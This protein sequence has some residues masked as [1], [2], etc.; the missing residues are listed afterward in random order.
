MKRLSFMR[1]YEK[2]INIV[3][4]SIIFSVFLNV[5]I[6]TVILRVENIIPMILLSSLLVAFVVNGFSLL[7]HNR[8]KC[9]VMYYLLFVL[10]LLWLFSSN[11]TADL[12][13]MSAIIFG[14]PAMMISNTKISYYWVTTFTLILGLILFRFI[15]VF[16]WIM[17]SD[18]GE[19]MYNSYLILSFI[20]FSVVGIYIYNKHKVVVV[21]S[22]LNLVIYVPIL[23]AIGVRGVYMSIA[24]FFFLIVLNTSFFAR[25][26]KSMLL[27]V[28][29]LVI[30]LFSID[31]FELIEN[32]R[33]WLADYDIEVYALEKYFMMFSN[34]DVSNGRFQ[35]Y[36]NAIFGF[37]S[38]PVWGNGLGVFEQMNEG[39][40]V[41][42]IFLEVLY[43]GGILLSIV[44]V[45]SFARF[46]KLVY[47]SMDI[48]REYY[49]FVILLFSLGCSILLFSNTLW[50][51]VAFW[52]FF[53]VTFDKFK[54]IEK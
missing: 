14:M 2:N 52:L 17:E 11:E 18:A 8:V 44:F 4:N 31:W 15:D 29:L 22:I 24:L 50:R 5:K 35:L 39:L 47:R 26:K 7:T 38:S 19:K 42:N 3:I 49:T 43:E 51:V 16:S 41:H 9:K 6:F 48:N 37:F 40:Y 34:D 46:S 53:G 32:L 10:T 20:L 28:L 27:I 13:Y 21:L 30:T 45:Y 33:L 23:L 12:Y 1:T 36:S 54:Y 25:N